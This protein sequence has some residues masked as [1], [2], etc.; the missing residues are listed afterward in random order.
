[1]KQ[2]ERRR[3]PERYFRLYVLHTWRGLD[4]ITGNQQPVDRRHEQHCRFVSLDGLGV[5]RR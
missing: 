5:A 1:M 2:K 3:V 4:Q